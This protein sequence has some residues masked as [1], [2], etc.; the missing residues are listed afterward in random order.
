MACYVFI[1]ACFFLVCL[2]LTACFWRNKDTYI[3]AA[4]A[5]AAVFAIIY[6]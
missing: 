2:F 5:A 1:F 4:V 6:R 3:I